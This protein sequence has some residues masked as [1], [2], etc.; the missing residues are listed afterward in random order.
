MHSPN[1]H[2]HDEKQQPTLPD[3]RGLEV[4]DTQVCQWHIKEWSKL[5][6]K[7]HGPMFQVGGYYWRLLLY[8]QGNGIR[9][10]VSLYLEIMTDELPDDWA[11]CAQ[12]CLSIA[13]PTKPNHRFDNH[14]THRFCAEEV[15]WGF[16]R[17]YDLK[18]LEK[19]H[20]LSHDQTVI[21][22]MLRTVKDPTG[23]LWRSFANYDSRKETGYVGIKN[24][25]A[26]CYMNSL[27]QSLFCINAFRLAV[28]QIPVGQE[29]SSKNVGL[30][31]QKVF[32]QL[33][34]SKD[35]INTTELTRSFGWDTVDGFMQ[36]DV[37]EF[38]RILLENLETKMKNT[39]ADGSIERLFVGKMKSFIKCIDVEYESS[40][41][42]DFYDIQLNVVDCPDVKASFQQYVQEETMDGENQYMAEGHG[43]QNARKGVIFERFPPVL[44][45][46]LKRFHYNA[47]DNV[48]VKIND[49][50]E[51]PSTLCLNEF[52]TDTSQEYTYQLQSVL[53]HSG[54]L[55][56]G[57]YFAIIHPGKEEKWF[58]FDDEFVIPVTQTEVF[59]D[60]FG[61]TT[62]APRM[63]LPAMSPTDATKNFT[64]AYMLV[65][66][67]KS[68]LDS[69]LHP[70]TDA[71]IPVHLRFGQKDLNK[72]CWIM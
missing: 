37:Q 26:T 53:V 52:C 66:L 48:M 46:H 27:L 4:T 16:T 29:H 31:L 33:E 23:V 47:V 45:L 42:E 50:Y 3:L 62:P 19:N 28:Y 30:A 34:Q 22:V 41:V 15:D 17:F 55:D 69:L 43:L 25:G 60:N 13:N 8:P 38:S 12:F 59:E 57:H 64:N 1:K 32:Y 9:D 51:F 61:Q 10:T 18:Q 14:T 7:C 63:A 54:D 21:S 35:P 71:D 36:H 49:R 6:Q 5:S 11:V 72:K 20:Y 40:R 56:S 68:L 44:H 67:Q 58:K 2:K 24:Q 65:Y 39:P 70:V